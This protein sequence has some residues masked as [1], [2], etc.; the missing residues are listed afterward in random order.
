[1]KMAGPNNI[2]T[3][4]SYV[5]GEQQYVSCNLCNKKFTRINYDSHLPECERKYK[6]K[7]GNKVVT[8]EEK[9]TSAAADSKSFLGIDA[10]FDANGTLT[11][12]DQLIE[13]KVAKLNAAYAELAKY[14]D[15]DLKY[16]DQEE[17]ESDADYKKWQKRHAAALEA[18]NAVARVEAQA[19]QWDKL[20]AQYEESQDLYWEK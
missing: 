17:K 8:T 10:K 1:M 6:D 20:L 18:Q 4:Q 13:A 14:T 11:N 12:Y 3:K 15:D 5:R 19:A 9:N 2:N 7:Q 16:R